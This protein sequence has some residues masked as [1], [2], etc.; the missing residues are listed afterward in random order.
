[1]DTMEAGIAVAELQ[2][3]YGKDA[4]NRKTVHPGDAGWDQV[5][6]VFDALCND[7]VPNDAALDKALED[8]FQVFHRPIL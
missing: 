8:F 5:A 7:E 2:M 1:V 4:V 3:V 6:A